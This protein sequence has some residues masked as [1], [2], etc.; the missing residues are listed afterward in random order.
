MHPTKT[1]LLPPLAALLLLR[2]AAAYEVGW[3]TWDELT[4][5]NYNP[6]PAT[7]DFANPPCHQIPFPASDVM[8]IYLRA[9]YALEDAPPPPYIAM[10]GSTDPAAQGCV[11]ASLLTLY[12]FDP[13]ALDKMQGAWIVSPGPRYWREL[14]PGQVQD[15]LAK[16]L[17]SSFPPFQIGDILMKIEA[18]PQAGAGYAWMKSQNKVF[19]EDWDFVPPENSFGAEDDEEEETGASAQQAGSGGS[20]GP[21]VNGQEDLG[22]GGVP[23]VLGSP[24]TGG[25]PNANGLGIGPGEMVLSPGIGGQLGGLGVGGIG[26]GALAGMGGGVADAA[27]LSGSQPNSAEVFTGADMAGLQEALNSIHIDEL[28]GQPELED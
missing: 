18:P 23:N 19:V 14:Y 25:L 4:Q 3:G 7:T 16:A 1:H 15:P 17:L 11:D 20:G 6:V 9:S 24:G 12:A 5:I 21:Q 27:L 26:G 8:E 22:T 10:Y 28:E 2:L 13:T